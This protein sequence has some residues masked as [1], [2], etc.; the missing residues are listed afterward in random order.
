MHI[1]LFFFNYKSNIAASGAFF[2]GRA[3]KALA[4]VSQ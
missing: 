1:E 3:K 4:V 2:A